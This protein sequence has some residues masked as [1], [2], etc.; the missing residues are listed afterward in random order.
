MFE[1]TSQDVSTLTE[2]KVRQNI[3]A[4]LSDK[5]EDSTIDR[6]Q[7]KEIVGAIFSHFGWEPKDGERFASYQVVVSLFDEELFTVNNVEA[8]SEYAAEAMVSDNIS[9]DSIRLQVEVSY[10]G[11]YGTYSGDGWLDDH[12]TDNLSYDVTE[13]D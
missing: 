5:V 8:N 7:A 9:I 12:V 13:E 10:E 4:G 3:V 2:G 11:D 6:G 1:E